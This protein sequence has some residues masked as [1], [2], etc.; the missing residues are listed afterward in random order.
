MSDSEFCTFIKEIQKDPFRKVEG[1]TI[2]KVY[3]LQ[4]HIKTCEECIRIID[5]VLEATKDV[6]EDPNSEWGKAQ[7]N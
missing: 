4:E 2:G 3:Q 7:Y 5:E 6:P 1:L